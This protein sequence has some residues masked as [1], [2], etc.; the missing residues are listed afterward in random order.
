MYDNGIP[1][2]ETDYPL[3]KLGIDSDLTPDVYLGDNR[4]IEFFVSSNPDYALLNKTAKYSKFDMLE[5]YYVYYDIRDDRVECIGDLN[6]ITGDYMRNFQSFIRMNYKYM[7][8]VKLDVNDLDCES[9]TEGYDY[10][11]REREFQF[12]SDLKEF[13]NDEYLNSLKE[14]KLRLYDLNDEGRYDIT[15]DCVTRKFNIISGNIPWGVINNNMNNIGYI[16]S[17]IIYKNAGVHEV[18]VVEKRIKKINSGYYNIGENHTINLET[19]PYRERCLELPIKSDELFEQLD[20]LYFDGLYK[21]NLSREI[22]IDQGEE[23]YIEWKDRCMNVKNPKIK[24]MTMIPIFDTSKLSLEITERIKFRNEFNNYLSDS[25]YCKYPETVKFRIS[26]EEEKAFVKTKNEIE[27][28]TKLMKSYRREWT[29]SYGSN[30]VSYKINVMNQAARSYLRTVKDSS[31]STQEFLKTFIEHPNKFESEYFEKMVNK[32]KMIRS[33]RRIS[34]KRIYRQNTITMGK[35]MFDL[36]KQER[37]MMVN[38]DKDRGEEEMGFHGYNGIMLFEEVSGLIHNFWNYLCQ[39]ERGVS[40]FFTVQASE[41]S[42]PRN[43]PGKDSYKMYQNFLTIYSKY[44]NTRIFNVLCLLSNISRSIW[45]I[46][47]YK[48]KK[49]NVIFDR[50][51]TKSCVLFCN[52]TGNIQKFK[53][54][55]M[56]KI[57]GPVNSLITEFCGMKFLPLSDLGYS[58]GTQFFIT[59]WMY[60]KIQHLKYFM[61][62]P[63]RWMQI[64]SILITEYSISDINDE[65]I[66]IITMNMLNARRKTEI[67]LHD[68]KYLTYNMF[69]V[70]GCYSDLLSDKF[71]IP[72][73]MWMRYLEEKFLRNIR[74][75]MVSLDNNNLLNVDQSSSYPSYRVIH[76]LVDRELDLDTFNLIVYSSYV[77]PKGVFTQ[78]TEQLVNMKGI[79]NIHDKAMAI[80]GDSNTYEDVKSKTD[81][82]ISDVFGNDLFFNSS[83]CS[84]IG[85]FAEADM[86]TLNRSANLRSAWYKIVNTDITEYANSHGLREDD[87]SEKSSWGKKGHDIMTSYIKKI[88]S[89]EDIERLKKITLTDNIQVSRKNKYIVESTKYTIADYAKSH[90][91]FEIEMNNANKVQWGGNRE[92]YIMTH[93]AKNIQ[94]ALEQM[95]KEISK[96][97]DNELIHIPSSSRMSLLYDSLK[98]QNMGIRYYMT[99]DCRK[100][101]PLSNLNKYIVFINS[102]TNILPNEFIRDFNYFFKLYYNKRLFFREE[103]VQ[104]FLVSKE[105]T[106]YKDYF[107]KAG[108]AYYIRMPYSFMM[109]MFNYLSSIF[110]AYSQKYFIRNVVPRIEAKWGCSI[111]MKMFAHSDDSGGYMEIYNT[112]KYNE[113]M[114]DVCRMYES[115][116][117]CCNHMLSLKKCVVSN[118]YFEITSYCF[119]KTDPMPVL[120]KFIYNH[121]INLTPSGL[122]SDIKSI[123]SDVTEMVCNG[124]SFQASY[125]KYISLGLTYRKFCLGKGINDLSSRTSYGLLGFPLIHPYYIMVYKNNYERKW[126]DDISHECYSRNLNLLE[127][128]DSVGPWGESRGIPVHL[129]TFKNRL[130][131]GRFTPFELNVEIPDEIIPSGHYYS[132]MAKMSNKYYRDTMWYSL[133]DID[134]TILQ[135]NMF[136]NGLAECYKVAGGYMGLRTLSDFA[137]IEVNISNKEYDPLEFKMDTYIREISDYLEYNSKVMYKISQVRPKPSHISTYYSKWWK[138][139]KRDLKSAMLG[140]YCPWM[141]YINA[142]YNDIPEILENSKNSSDAN[143]VSELN[144]EDPLLSI[145]I[146]SRSNTRL[147]D[148]YDIIGSWY[149]TNQYP[150]QSP[151]RL[152][153]VGSTYV[154]SDKNIHPECVASYL[155]DCKMNNDEIN[156]NDISVKMQVQNADIDAQVSCMDWLRR[157]AITDSPIV[158]LVISNRQ[159]DW[160][161]EIDFIAIRHNQ[162][163]DKGRY[164]IGNTTLYA[165][166]SMRN[167]ILRVSSGK[168]TQI[169]CGDHYNIKHIRSD[170]ETLS[171]YGF[172]YDLYINDN[173]FRKID[174]ITSDLMGNWEWTSIGN[175]SRY[176]S[177]IIYNSDALLYNRIGIYNM[178]RDEVGDNFENM[179]PILRK[180]L[181]LLADGKKIKAYL[182]HRKP[183]KD[184]LSKLLYKGD[185]V[186]G[187]IQN[188]ECTYNQKELIDNFRSTHLYNKIYEFIEK[189]QDI[190]CERSRYICSPGSLLS[191]LYEGK[192]DKNAVTYFMDYKEEM[193]LN[194]MVEDMIPQSRV[195]YIKTRLDEFCKI[196]LI[197]D[198][199]YLD[200]DE[201]R[202][203]EIV[204]QEGV[205]SVCTAL[206]LMPIKRSKEYYTPM[207]FT[208]YWYNNTEVFPLFI[209]DTL[210]YISNTIDKQEGRMSDKK[211][212]FTEICKEFYK[213]VVISYKDQYERKQKW[214]NVIDLRL[215]HLLCLFKDVGES[216]D[217]EITASF[218]YDPVSILG[219]MKGFLGYFSCLSNRRDGELV[220]D[221]KKNYKQLLDAFYKKYK[222]YCNDKFGITVN[223]IQPGTI[224]THNMPYFNKRIKDADDDDD[225]TIVCYPLRDCYPMDFNDEPE[226]FDE[227]VMTMDVEESI[228][229][230]DFDPNANYSC[231]NQS[232]F[233]EEGY[234]TTCFVMEEEEMF[235]WVPYD[236]MC[237][238]LVLKM[239]KGILPIASI[240]GK[241]YLTNAVSMNYG[242]DPVELLK[243]RKHKETRLIDHLL[244]Q[245]NRRALMSMKSKKIISLDAESEQYLVKNMSL[246]GILEKNNILSKVAGS[247]PDI[248][249]IIEGERNYERITNDAEPLKLDNFNKEAIAELNVIDKDIIPLMSSGSF[250]LTQNAY[251]ELMKSKYT[252]KFK[253]IETLTFYKTLLR[254][255]IVTKSP[256]NITEKVFG[257]MLKIRD[258]LSDI[259]TKY[260][261]NQLPKPNKPNP[262]EIRVTMV[263]Y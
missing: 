255:A 231:A 124:S 154:H 19:Q 95:F 248:T 237:T 94:W 93:T 33:N 44:K 71:I 184:C 180:N 8:Y 202:M 187:V 38:N 236:N 144:S 209:R 238:K 239:N 61:E 62:I 195:N 127:T 258:M 167:Y 169:E 112:S 147:L 211:D 129:I 105:N 77:F 246:F 253:S 224:L 106:K 173:K 251:D 29:S 117:K 230:W 56:F 249:K 21:N 250:R 186:E 212:A 104:S 125:F 133:H 15:F 126:L 159:S 228:E 3:R 53:S 179:L 64:I 103:D 134:G 54:S 204:E 171:I 101:A 114:T 121:Q 227:D 111:A 256:D 50:C 191:C 81:V 210:S 73:D 148:R 51:G 172:S 214:R 141:C 107:V 109:G 27:E 200:V 203:N 40:D 229:D 242:D 174:R 116:Q 232:I 5:I 108:C 82:Q 1:I 10:A 199:V 13:E 58:G 183:C 55:K 193:S 216:R 197:D 218:Y 241:F 165:R 156:A 31:I 221:Y 86:I 176:Y 247:G 97:V 42:F 74:P 110:H 166:I 36:S 198:E 194:S 219:S 78:Y 25:V 151:E 43:L 205:S 164:W 11:N 201:N 16:R 226:E 185:K 60:L 7:R 175:G 83:V 65:I 52:G 225:E 6:F 46:S 91:K 120:P 155:I 189:N 118:S 223:K 99:L 67:L 37:S 102:M 123:S 188:Y 261:D 170:L 34:K 2:V 240:E 32:T 233:R 220:K 145:D 20:A 235:N 245:S 243:N 39:Y 23:Y 234:E 48:T 206:A 113:V 262:H 122:I 137:E 257:I 182:I 207:T 30:E 63:M 47:T 178:T 217:D 4:F 115:F 244:A 41:Y 89:V 152:R 131:D 208:M 35:R 22:V 119:V 153:R 79:M 28:L 222:T 136:N 59:H 138:G 132:Y 135:S 14:L 213:W 158:R 9:I 76:P 57:M 45:A 87:L 160:I 68:M 90:K 98:K 259:R 196:N 17:V 80:L 181:Y 260:D 92:I 140:K 12:E 128:L 149:F 177:N 96:L 161:N 84:A 66:M 139:N 75:F 168:I 49:R 252:Y 150:M 146:L 18:D 70:K 100:W 24:M 190:I 157:V 85:M 263:E 142:D 88:Y 130:N 192:F 254:S 163:S 69:G 215:Y 26:K 72:K 162:Y 143:I